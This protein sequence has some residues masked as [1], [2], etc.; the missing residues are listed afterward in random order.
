MEPKTAAGIA[1]RVCGT[2]WRG[3]Q[4]ANQQIDWRE[5]AAIFGH[6]LV[7]LVVLAYYAGFELGRAVRR[8]NGVLAALWRRLWVP[9]AAPAQPAVHP[10]AMIADELQTLSC[11]QLRQVGGIRAKRSKAYLIGA[12]CAA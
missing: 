2:A 10:L 11:R 4:W 9:P 3:L 7:A 1:G 5:V 8:A 6:G 12:I